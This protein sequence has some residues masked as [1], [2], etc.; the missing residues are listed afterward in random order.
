MGAWWLAESQATDIRWRCW[1]QQ[2]WPAAP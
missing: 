2:I 1:S